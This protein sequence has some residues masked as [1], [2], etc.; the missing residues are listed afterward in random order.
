MHDLHQP[1]LSS[2]AVRRVIMPHNIDDLRTLVTPP[3]EPVDSRPEAWDV[4]SAKL[5]TALPRDWRIFGVTY[6]SGT[7]RDAQDDFFYLR[8]YNPLSSSFVDRIQAICERE[9]ASQAFHERFAVFPEAA[10]VLPLGEDNANNALWFVAEGPADKWPILVCDKAFNVKKYPMPL[11][12]FI[13]SLLTGAISLWVDGENAFP[14][15]VRFHPER[16]S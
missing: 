15:G 13:V 6:G 12:S 1:T 4:N 3:P 8:F 14:S 11:I 7:F 5:R 9:R 10:G 16:S 2:T